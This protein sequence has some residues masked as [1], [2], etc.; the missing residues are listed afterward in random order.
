MAQPS[1]KD[2]ETIIDDTLI[3]IILQIILV[4]VYTIVFVCTVKQFGKVLNF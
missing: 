4:S 2:F 3:Y 1:L